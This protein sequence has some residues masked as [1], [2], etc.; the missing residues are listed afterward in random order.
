MKVPGCSLGLHS[1]IK[2]VQPKPAEQ[3]NLHAPRPVAAPTPI[4]IAANVEPVSLPVKV[5]ATKSFL[6][7]A[8]KYKCVN[9]GCNKEY[10][11]ED[12]DTCS[13]HPGKPI[14]RDTKKQWTCCEKHAYDWDDFVK[15]PTCQSGKH[16]PKTVSA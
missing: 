14:F 15:I 6:T 5:E 1:D 12:N 9:A 2:P 4:P 16:K 7:E 11:P 3:P 10:D 8:G 13:F